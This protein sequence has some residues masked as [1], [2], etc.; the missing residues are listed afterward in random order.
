M[1]YVQFCEKMN[2]GLGRSIVSL[3]FPTRPTS[4]MRDGNYIYNAIL[5]DEQL[6]DEVNLM[7][8]MEPEQFLNEI[9]LLPEPQQSE[10]LRRAYARL[11]W[12]QEK[13]LGVDE[14]TM[15]FCIVCET[16]VAIPTRMEDLFV[17]TNIDNL[18]S[19]DVWPLEEV[20][21]EL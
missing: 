2:G 19:P 15:V 18:Y 11:K 12:L 20:W 13:D 6:R 4:A 7:E 1:V 16:W 10:V 21:I 3:S 14:Q 9:D 17:D 8:F 5:T